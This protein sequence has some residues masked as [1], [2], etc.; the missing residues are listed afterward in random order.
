M[1]LMADSKLV[2]AMRT[3]VT[4]ANR[5][6]HLSEGRDLG[7]LERATAEY[8]AA[9]DALQGALVARGWRLPGTMDPGLMRL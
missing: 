1:L 5:V 6:Q 4:M 9:A 2:D 3:F 7:A 8:R